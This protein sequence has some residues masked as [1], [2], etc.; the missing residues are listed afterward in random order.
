MLP[1]AS[2]DCRLP[3]G[4]SHMTQR[5]GLGVGNMSEKQGMF[6]AE[7]GALAS[8]QVAQRCYL[9]VFH[10]LLCVRDE[11]PRLQSPKELPGC[12]ILL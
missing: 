4:P 3:M 12:G 6:V 7:M 11:S 1:T 8:S 5:G 2:C 9:P 10:M